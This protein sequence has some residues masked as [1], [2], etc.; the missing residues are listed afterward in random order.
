[1]RV[2]IQNKRIARVSFVPVSRDTNNDVFRLDPASDEGAKRVGMVRDRSRS[3]PPLRL[4]G[5]E[6]VLLGA[7][8]STSSARR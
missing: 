7:R 5:H 1:M 6:V 3:P 4:H 8:A 2:V